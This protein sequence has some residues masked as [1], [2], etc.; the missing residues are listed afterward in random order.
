MNCSNNVH[1]WHY[2]GC[3]NWTARTYKRY[4][5]TH[6]ITKML[7]SYFEREKRRNKSMIFL[8]ARAIFICVC[9]RLAFYWKLQFV[10][11]CCVCFFSS[12]PF[13]DIF[14]RLCCRLGLS[15]VQSKKN[16]NNIIITL[17][18]FFCWFLSC[19][20]RGYNVLRTSTNLNICFLFFS[21]VPSFA[22]VLSPVCRTSATTTWRSSGTTN[23]WREEKWKKKLKNANRL[24]LEQ[25]VLR[26]HTQFSWIS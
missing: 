14:K 23:L 20:A 5:R 11:Q 1:H 18:K 15:L 2:H 4:K 13:C 10:L 8:C 12:F 16:N 24:K 25:I 19:D 3:L 9:L 6:L 22:T 26:I 17:E 7:C 21:F